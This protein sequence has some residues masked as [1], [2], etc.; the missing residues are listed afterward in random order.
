MLPVFSPVKK[1]KSGLKNLPLQWQSPNF[2][3]STA[4][5]VGKQAFTGAVGIFEFPLFPF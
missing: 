2:E 1:E 4:F 5:A 3:K